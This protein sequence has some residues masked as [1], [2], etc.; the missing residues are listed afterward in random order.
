ML[1]RGRDARRRRP[2]RG[3]RRPRSRTAR[4]SRRPGPSRSSAATTGPDTRCRRAS[5]SAARLWSSSTEATRGVG[6]QGGDGGVG[7]LDGV[8]PEGGDRV[9]VGRA[10]VRE[11]GGLLGGRRA[12]DERDDVR[13][14]GD[15]RAGRGLGRGSRGVGGRGV[16]AGLGVASGVGSGGAEWRP[17]SH[18]GSRSGRVSRPVSARESDPAWGRRAA[19]TDR[20]TGRS[21]V[22]GSA[23]RSEARTLRRHRPDGCRQRE[24]QQEHLQRDQ[25][26]LDMPNTPR[27]GGRAEHRSPLPCPNGSRRPLPIP[28]GRAL[29]WISAP[30]MNADRPYDREEDSPIRDRPTVPVAIPRNHP[31][32]HTAATTGARQAP[33]REAA[34]RS[35]TRRDLGRGDTKRTD[36]RTGRSSKG[37]RAGSATRP[38]GYGAAAWTSAIRSLASDVRLLIV[39]LL[40]AG[41]PWASPFRQGPDLAGDLVSLRQPA[42]RA[43]RRPRRRPRRRSTEPVRI[44]AVANFRLSMPTEPNGAVSCLYAA[45]SSWSWPAVDVDPVRDGVAVEDLEDRPTVVGVRRRRAR[46]S[47]SIVGRTSVWSVQTSPVSPRFR[48]PG[49]TKPSQVLA[50]SGWMSP[51]FQ[52][53]G[54]VDAGHARARREV[55]QEVVRVGEVGEGRVPVRIAGRVHVEELHLGLVGHRDHQRCR[56][57]RCTG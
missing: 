48:M 22:A 50:I 33:R 40:G 26:P 47:A 3:R 16:G 55:G 39:A 9:D 2:C 46:A 30:E 25:Q 44:A 7:G 34:R 31:Q 56:S 6:A 14:D 38:R 23:R 1:R 11:R 28:L 17:A 5:P 8:H 15:R 54:R 10:D 21:T 51:W 49:P 42:S 57:L 37:S 43:S 24:H 20:P 36:P 52:A 35:P 29:W 12:G 41:P 18:R 19:S 13:G 27:C 32:P 53:N 45:P 4:P